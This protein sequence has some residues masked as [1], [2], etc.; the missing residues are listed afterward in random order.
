MIEKSF[1]IITIANLITIPEEK[2]LKFV[3]AVK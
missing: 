3:S 1:D 2:I